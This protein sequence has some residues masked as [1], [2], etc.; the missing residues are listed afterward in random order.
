MKKMRHL[1]TKLME[2]FYFKV[3]IPQITYCF[4]VWVT[5]SVAM[6]SEIENLHIEV[7]R[8]F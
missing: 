3:V 6:L 8:V 2:A 5:C 7:E 1:P 4:S